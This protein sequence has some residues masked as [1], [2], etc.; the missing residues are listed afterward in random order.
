MNH[1]ALPHSQHR[2]LLLS[3]PGNGPKENTDWLVKQAFFY[4]ANFPKKLALIL[5]YGFQSDTIMFLPGYRDVFLW[6]G[7]PVG[8][9]KSKCNF[10]KQLSN[11]G[12]K[13]LFDHRKNPRAQRLY[14]HRQLYRGGLAEADLIQRRRPGEKRN[15]RRASKENLMTGEF[16]IYGCGLLSSSGSGGDGASI[17]EIVTFMSRANTLSPDAGMVGLA[18]HPLSIACEDSGKG[19]HKDSCSPSCSSMLARPGSEELANHPK[20]DGDPTW[21]EEEVLSGSWG[22]PRASTSHWVTGNLRRAEVGA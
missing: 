13:K 4:R 19:T 3:P 22:N 7:N 10:E 8:G 21:L 5:H 14:H 11:Y 18:P 6:N 16:L 15:H 2:D 12:I 9:L 20:V 1:L 17:P